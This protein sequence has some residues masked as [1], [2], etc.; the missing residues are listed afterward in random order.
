MST[1]PHPLDI[2]YIPVDERHDWLRVK[3]TTP[4]ITSNSWVRLKRRAEL[5]VLLENERLIKYAKDLAYVHRWLTDSLVMICLVPRLLVPII[6]EDAGHEEAGRKKKRCQRILHP[7]L[8]I[9]HGSSVLLIFDA[10]FQRDCQPDRHQLWLKV[11]PLALPH[12][13]F[14]AAITLAH[15]L[16]SIEAQ[17]YKG[18]GYETLGV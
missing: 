17:R 13:R 5:Q 15:C 2:R 1:F 10:F 14:H 7:Q 18:R 16:V 12:V 3:H 11:I 4:T 9:D 6:S 8:P